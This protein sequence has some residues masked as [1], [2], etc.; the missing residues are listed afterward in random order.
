MGA[1]DGRAR[2]AVCRPPRRIAGSAA[3]A[4]EDARA[5]RGE[6]RTKSVRGAIVLALFVA[7]LAAALRVGHAVVDPVLRNVFGARDGQRVGEVVYSIPDGSFCRRL[8]FDNETAA[9]SE[10]AVEPCPAN[11]PKWACAATGTLPGVPVDG[12]FR[13][14]LSLFC[15]WEPAASARTIDGRPTR[16]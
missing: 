8:P 1:G 7:L 12:A 14:F 4:A 16:R 10:G 6:R 5:R 15:G 13:A 3:A 11:L 9:L 2:I